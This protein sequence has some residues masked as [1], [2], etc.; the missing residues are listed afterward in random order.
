MLGFHEEVTFV[1]KWP[2]QSKCRWC[3]N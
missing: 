1:R 3:Y 2:A